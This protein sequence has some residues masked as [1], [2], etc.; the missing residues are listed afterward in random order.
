MECDRLTREKGYLHKMT[1]IHDLR[2]FGVLKFRDTAFLNAFGNVSKLGKI[3]YFSFLFKLFI[4]ILYY[5]KVIRYIH[6]YYIVV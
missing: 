3:K 2:N 6:S 1:A 5:Q 4:Y